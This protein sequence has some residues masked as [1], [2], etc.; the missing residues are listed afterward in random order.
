MKRKVSHKAQ[1]ILVWIV[2]TLLQSRHVM[3][4]ITLAVALLFR[5]VYFRKQIPFRDKA[6]GG[7]T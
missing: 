5:P 2:L 1:V 3:V 7:A 6:P 4:N